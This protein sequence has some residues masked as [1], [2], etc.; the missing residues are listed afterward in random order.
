[1]K[2][3][4]AFPVDLTD[5]FERDC[6]GDDADYDRIEEVLEHIA[7]LQEAGTLTRMAPIE[8]LIHEVEEGETVN[9]P[10]SSYKHWMAECDE[11][12]YQT[13]DESEGGVPIKE[14]Y[15]SGSEIHVAGADE[16]DD[17]EDVDN[18]RDTLLDTVKTSPDTDDD[19][20]ESDVAPTIETKPPPPRRAWTPFIEPVRKTP[21][22][23]TPTALGKGHRLSSTFGAVKGSGRRG[24]QQEDGEAGA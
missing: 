10:R 1:M 12:E 18:S 2:E 16:E 24:W 9:N 19:D 20:A 23:L 5:Q 22:K 3:E 11:M 15:A 13:P 8:F 21:Y 4:E 7:D 6:C 14:E 17:E